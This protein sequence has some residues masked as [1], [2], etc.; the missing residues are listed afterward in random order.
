MPTGDL[1]PK[2]RGQAAVEPS[3]FVVDEA[4]R[5]GEPGRAELILRGRVELA[6]LGADP[7]EWV[8]ADTEAEL[9]AGR[10]ENTADAIRWAFGALIT[11]CGRVDIA[12]KHDPPSAAT[13]RNWIKAHWDMT[14][15]DKNGEVVKRGRRAQPYAPNTVAMRVYLVAMVCNRLGWLSPTRDPKVSEQLVVYRKKFERA[16]FRTFEADPLTP[17]LSVANVRKACDLGTVNGLRNATAFRMQF[18]TGCRATEMAEGLLGQHVRWITDYRV[19]VTFVETKGGKT[20][21]V[22]LEALPDIDWDVDPVH[23]LALYCAARA[24]FG[25][26]DSDP[27]FTEVSHAPRRRN[28]FAESGIYAGKILRQPWTYEAYVECWNRAVRKSKIDIGPRGTRFHFPSH[29]NRAGMITGAVQAGIPSEITRKRSGH[30][31]GSPVFER[32]YRG[33]DAVGDENVGA[34]IRRKAAADQAQRDAERAARSEKY[35]ASRGGRPA[36]KK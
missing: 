28:D 31:E 33:A 36:K 12:R 5:A 9:Q 20:R 26:G 35:W 16:G 18:D 7:D 15:L 25:L 17:E 6:R 1:L 2:R 32:Y 3:P 27:F 22:F 10:S 34:I 11:Y 14:R 19:A 8:D 13:M 21:T 29:S 30:A 24:Q 23:L 4:D